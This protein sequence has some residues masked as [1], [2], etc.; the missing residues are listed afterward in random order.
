MTF[1]RNARPIGAIR[2]ALFPQNL[3][4]KIESIRFGSRR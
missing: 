2:F 1:T 4:F 3:V